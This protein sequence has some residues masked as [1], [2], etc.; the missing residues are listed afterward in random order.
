M[1]LIRADEWTNMGWDDFEKMCYEYLCLRYPDTEISRTPRIRDGGKDIVL[2]V[3]S[4][5]IDSEI[6]VECKKH[7]RPIG[8]ETLGKNVVLIVIRNIQMLIVMSASPVTEG[9]KIQLAKFA[10][11]SNFRIKFLDGENLGRELSDYPQILQKYLPDLSLSTRAMPSVDEVQVRCYVSEFEENVPLEN[12]DD[13]L[14][15][16]RDD[17]FY[18][19]VFLKNVS[20]EKVRNIRVHF[21]DFDESVKIS[22]QS[23]N[24]RFNSIESMEDRTCT[25]YC[26]VLS[27]KRVV[28]LPELKVEYAT[29]DGTKK[30]IEKNTGHVDK[31]FLRKSPLIG[32]KN[33]DFIG[34]RIPELI[35]DIRNGYAKLIDIR[36]V[37]GVGKTR[38][39]N[40]IASEMKSSGFQVISFDCRELNDY[41]LFRRF[42]S[43]LI[44]LPLYQGYVK[45]NA[46]A[47]KRIFEIYGFDVSYVDK[48]HS[49]LVGTEI[50][51]D[52]HFYLTETLKHFLACRPKESPL[53][54]FIDNIQELNP[55]AV[56]VVEELIEFTKD[57]KS[58]VCLVVSTNTEI[59]PPDLYENVQSFLK[60]ID[61]MRMN[62]R[63]FI[64]E[65]ECEEFSTRDARLFVINR[66]PEIHRNDR[67]INML[68][69]K[70]GRRVL[71]LEILM[72]FMEDSGALKM[73]DFGTWY[74]PDLSKLKEV[75]ETIPKD[76]ARIVEKRM[77]LLEKVHEGGQ[78]R[79]IGKTLESIVAFYGKIPKSCLEDLGVPSDV[80]D[81]LVMKSFI[82]YDKYTDSLVFY[83]ENLYR[84]FERMYPD[85]AKSTCRR[86]LNWLEGTEFS[87]EIEHKY[88]IAFK[89]SYQLQDRKETISRGRDA[90]LFYSS[91]QNHVDAVEVGDLLVPYLERMGYHQTE[92]LDY[93]DMSWKYAESLLH[94]INVKRGLESYH[95]LYSDLRF[96]EARIPKE[97]VNGFMHNSV[98]A[99]LHNWRYSRA[100]ELLKEHES[101]GTTDD[102]ARFLI[103][104]RYAVLYTA[105]GDQEKA[106]M[107]IQKS[108]Q[109]ARGMEDTKYLSIAYSDQGYIHLNITY[110]KAKIVEGFRAA[111]RSFKES[112]DRPVFR[113]IEIAQ[114]EAIIDFLEKRYTK[115]YRHIDQALWICKQ[116]HY[117]LFQLRLHNLKAASQIMEGKYEEAEG[118][119]Q[120]ARSTAEIFF[121]EKS[122]WRVIANLG[123]LHFIQGNMRKARDYYEISIENLSRQLPEATSLTK[124]LPLLA[125]MILLYYLEGVDSELNDIIARYPHPKLMRYSIYLRENVSPHELNRMER[126][127]LFCI[128]GDRG[129]SLFIT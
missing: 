52:I 83:H 94:H 18:I 73:K 108:L 61:A 107:Y 128:A 72:Y 127:D 24:C 17:C 8:L 34:N 126:L 119:L 65:F 109:I 105:L 89:C 31:V 74:I 99:N 23:W 42:L 77:L 118:T 19:H 5:L 57:Q 55:N 113:N 51:E 53:T 95:K 54:I 59:I 104:D 112:S 101:M 67:I 12:G 123:S 91:M 25:F 111:I 66:F 78:W 80:I 21:G 32:E 35:G 85:I 116:N 98:N 4:P 103:Y 56:S 129:V 46:E 88:K 36:G 117:T 96:T 33:I 62:H 115:A 68:V 7:K 1:S 37:S 60:R 2:L 13:G 81:L 6:W 38:L 50:K 122:R 84:F 75:I 114:Q 14:K 41:R 71:D 64:V 30:E 40:E 15:L 76:S 29:V 3:S 43:H 110:D 86:I 93:F 90:L 47:L 100:I 69:E 121:S 11:K 58:S 106:E 48:I 92:F 26:R 70:A 28:Q 79:D 125:N 45:Y 63:D 27:N 44:G 120:Y 82:R 102:N 20:K 16:K 87:E 124:E 39:M 10:G 22:G 97:L 49:F 9:A